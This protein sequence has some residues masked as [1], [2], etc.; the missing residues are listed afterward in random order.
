MPEYEPL[1]DINLYNLNRIARRDPRD[2]L[3]FPV[4]DCLFILTIFVNWRYRHA[5]E[6]KQLAGL[7]FK[8]M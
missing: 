2:I 7:C 1:F 8:A 6:K 5:I 3:Q 4:L